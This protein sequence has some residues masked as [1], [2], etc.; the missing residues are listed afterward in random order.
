MQEW[1]RSK[2][3]FC[4]VPNSHAKFSRYG[5]SPTACEK[6]NTL[7]T[8]QGTNAHMKAH[9]WNQRLNLYPLGVGA[10]GTV[11]VGFLCQ[12]D[13]A[14]FG[15]NCDKIMNNNKFYFLLSGPYPKSFNLI[16]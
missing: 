5:C 12:W 10:L 8:L 16:G 13:F 9:V 2:G 6:L 14:R 4:V 7:P 1:R 3:D 15:E 11:S